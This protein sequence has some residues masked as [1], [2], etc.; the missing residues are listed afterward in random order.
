MFAGSDCC[1]GVGAASI[2]G[3][4]ATAEVGN[5]TGLVPEAPS[6]LTP[7][8]SGQSTASS[9]AVA[10]ASRSAFFLRLSLRLLEADGVAEALPLT[11]SRLCDSTKAEAMAAAVA[12]TVRRGA[13]ACT[14]ALS[15]SLSR[16]EANEPLLD[17]IPCTRREHT[18]TNACTLEPGA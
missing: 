10:T 14:R 6:N 13:P 8:S 18:K 3:T 5:S 7:A 17:A 15:A 2:L 9:E 4:S 16:A 1:N 11:P 12:A